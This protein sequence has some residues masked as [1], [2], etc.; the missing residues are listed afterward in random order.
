MDWIL[1]YGLASQMEGQTG[2]FM[3]SFT[4]GRAHW[5]LYGPA[6]GWMDRLGTLWTGSQMDRLDTYGLA[7]GQPDRQTGYFMNWFTDGRMDGL[8]I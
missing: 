3:D 5:I 6:Y 1:N 7:H 2:Y 8:F 4:D